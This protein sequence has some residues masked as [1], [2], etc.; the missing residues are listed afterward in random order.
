[1]SVEFRNLR[2]IYSSIKRINLA[3]A[4]GHRPDIFIFAET[5]MEHAEQPAIIGYVPVAYVRARRRKNL[6][7]ASG[8]ISVYRRIGCTTPIRQIRAHCG[9]KSCGGHKCAN[10]LCKLSK[11]L[12]DTVTLEI[13]GSEEPKDN[14]T[15]T[16]YYFPPNQLAERTTSYFGAMAEYMSH[17]ADS[18][19][20]T[21]LV[22]DSNGD[23][24]NHGA[25][26]YGQGRANGAAEALREAERAAHHTWMKPDNEGAC[27]TRYAISKLKSKHQINQ[28]YSWSGLIKNS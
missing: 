11:S 15:V 2:G 26:R 23:R 5:W 1:M 3:T 25:P 28:E 14:V 12:T 18:G 13:G 21:I 7:R 6:G 8:G 4:S 16:D 10:K 20:R 24:D 27:H 9:S 19:H 17:L 22:G